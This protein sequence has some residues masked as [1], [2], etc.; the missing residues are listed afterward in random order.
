MIHP[1]SSEN[2]SVFKEKAQL[3]ETTGQFLR[4]EKNK[5]CRHPT[6]K[7]SARVSLGC[8]FFFRKNQ[9]DEDFFRKRLE[10]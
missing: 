7:D 9:G 4:D 3:S 2:Y 1:R 5:G 6:R 10:G 8:R